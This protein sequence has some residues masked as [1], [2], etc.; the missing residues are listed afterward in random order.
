MRMVRERVDHRNYA[1]LNYVDLV[2]LSHGAG[3]EQLLLNWLPYSTLYS[4]STESFPDR[5][6]GL[7]NP[8]VDSTKHRTSWDRLCP[9]NQA[10]RDA[11]PRT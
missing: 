2:L 10:D 5:C 9:A 6:R 1:L 4:A 3:S 11:R 7:C 8:R